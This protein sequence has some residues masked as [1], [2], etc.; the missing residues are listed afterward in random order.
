MDMLK[1]YFTEIL[2][3]FEDEKTRPFEGNELVLKIRNDLPK[4][5]SKC[6]DDTFTVRVH[7]G[8]NSWPKSPWI[9]IIDESF[10]SAQEALILQYN[11]DTLKREVSLSLILRLKDVSEYTSLKDFLII[12]IKD[13]NLNDFTIDENDTSSTILSKKYAYNQI[14]DDLL[15]GDLQSIIPTY[16]H[17]TYCFKSF[18][19]EDDCVMYDMA[20]DDYSSIDADAEFDKIE[21]NEVF[22]R[23]VIKKSIADISV[24]YPKENKYENN[25]NDPKDLFTDEAVKLIME[26]DITEKDYSEI[27]QDIQKNS[28][29]LLLKILRDNDLDLSELKIKDKILLYSKSFT[30]TEYKSIGKLL[31]SYSFNKIRID[32]RLPTPLIITSIIHE[33][34]HFLLE[35]ILKEVM[36]KILNTNDTPLISSY[37]KILLEDNDLNYLLDEF[38]AHTVEGRFALYGY[39]DYSS[40]KYKLDEISHLY[41]KE[42]IDYALILANSFAYDIKDILE[43]YID[44]DLREDIKDEFLRLNEKPQ[45]EPLDLEIET[46]LEG[47][48][49]RDALSLILTSGIGEAIAQKDKLSRYM[50]KFET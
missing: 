3:R 35:K 12:N 49:F 38:S 6:L 8:R 31:G 39:Q 23:R 20:F 32:D 43:E 9:T 34:S 1:D 5:V 4:E 44:E 28:R 7:C 15:K 19:D 26:C 22:S 37:V 16:R 41:S 40:F 50:V 27:L 21:C 24:D 29:N 25:I 18:F 13:T 14:N 10:D 45:Y 17:L 30:K 11:F 42:D 2:D 48:D 33:L 36:M 47:D 46:R